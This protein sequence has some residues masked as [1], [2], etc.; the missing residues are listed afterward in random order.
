MELEAFGRMLRLKWYFRNE[1]KNIHRDMFK[2]KSKF[3]PHNN[4][5]A[6]E[7]YLFSLEEKF[8][9]VKVPKA[10]LQKTLYDL[11]TPRLFWKSYMQS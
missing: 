2:S 3:N 9:K 7:L 4:D 1:N 10:K 8:L 6:I 5:A 11:T